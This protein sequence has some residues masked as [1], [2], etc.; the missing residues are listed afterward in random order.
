[1]LFFCCSV[2]LDP[3]LRAVL[4]L[5]PPPLDSILLNKYNF[6]VSNRTAPL[7]GRRRVLLQQ[8][9][10]SADSPGNTPDRAE[11][12]DVQLIE[13]GAWDLLIEGSVDLTA[14]KNRH[15]LQ[16]SNSTANSTTKTYNSSVTTS[17]NT[18]GGIVTYWSDYYASEAPDPVD[19]DPAPP[20]PP[21][22]ITQNT[23]SNSSV[24]TN[25]NSTAT[26]GALMGPDMGNPVQD[27]LSIEPGV[28][29][30]KG[31]TGQSCRCP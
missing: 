8:G 30:I 7:G 13:R 17:I 15:L 12:L 26:G 25:S 24:T 14:I 6:S 23:S 29:T 31:E 5:I 11:G 10:Y 20:I 3:G 28:T 1:M 9:N 27:S 22:N 19:L 4:T 2:S 21:F 16:S 18:S